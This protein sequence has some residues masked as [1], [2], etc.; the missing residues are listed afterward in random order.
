MDNP[1]KQRSEGDDARCTS[2]LYSS[3][4]VIG[5]PQIHGSIMKSREYKNKKRTEPLCFLSNVK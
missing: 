3:V 4:L 2:S 5:S 1:S